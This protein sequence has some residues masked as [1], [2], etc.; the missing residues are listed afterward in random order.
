MACFFNLPVASVTL[1]NV[2]EIAA[3]L[4][5]GPGAWHLPHTGTGSIGVPIDSAGQMHRVGGRGRL[6]GDVGS[7]YW[8][9]RQ[10]LTRVWR[11]EDDQRGAGLATPLAQS[12][13]AVIGGSSWDA[14]RRF[15]HRSRRGEFGRLAVAAAADADADADPAAAALLHGAGRAICILRCARTLPRR[16]RQARN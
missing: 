5:F 14:A 2:V 13:H 4:V 12:L 1:G 10:A 11:A 3:R 8:I 15:V 6:L 16:C 7:G 9:A